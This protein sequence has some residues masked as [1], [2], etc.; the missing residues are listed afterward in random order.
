VIEGGAKDAEQVAERMLTAPRSFADRTSISAAIDFS[1]A[2]FAG[3]SFKSDRRVINILVDGT[4]NSDCNVIAAPDEGYNIWIAILG[5]EQ[6]FSSTLIGQADFSLIATIMRL[7]SWRIRAWLRISG[8]MRFH[9]PV[10]SRFNVMG[11]LLK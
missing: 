2:H 5:E 1:M 10:K 6:N 11:S 9:F 7:A 4:N 3:S 8:S